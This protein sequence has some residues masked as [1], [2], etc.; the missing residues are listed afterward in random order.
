MQQFN[1]ARWLVM[2]EATFTIERADECVWLVDRRQPEEPSEQGS[3]ARAFA[4]HVTASQAVELG[5]ALLAI[6]SGKATS[7]VLNVG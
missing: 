3:P 1:Y 2:A 6:G 7:N 4:M 5:T